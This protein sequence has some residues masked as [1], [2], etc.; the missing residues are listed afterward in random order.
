M[1][2]SRPSLLAHITANQDP[3]VLRMVLVAGGILCL[4]IGPLLSYFFS[5][6]RFPLWV[7][8]ATGLA[9]LSVGILAGFNK[10]IRKNLP[11]I[12]FLVFIL[13]Y[14]ALIFLAYLNRL[15]FGFAGVLLVVQVLFALSFRRLG[16]FA[17]FGM[18]SILLFTLCSL[19][20]SQLVVPA[21]LFVLL[22]SSATIASGLYLWLRE[23][24]Q[25]RIQ[26]AGLLLD[27]MLDHAS[28]AT[29][30]LDTHGRQVLYANRAGEQFFQAQ[31]D[32]S[33]LTAENLL[34]LFDL[35]ASFLIV[36]LKTPGN[37]EE[38]SHALND[39]SEVD[40]Q[41]RKLDLG[42]H[43]AYLIRATLRVTPVLNHTANTYLPDSFLQAI[44]DVFISLDYNGNILSLR[45]PHHFKELQPVGQFL[46]QHFSVLSLMVMSKTKQKEAEQLLESATSSGLVQQ[47]EFMTV[48]AEQ[49]L[50]YDLRIVPVPE[51][52]KILAII[53]DITNNIEVEQALSQSEQNYREIF[54]SV[55][56]GLLILDPH[57]FNAYASNQVASQILGYS[58]EDLSERSFLSLNA[59]PQSAE[60]E[61]LLQQENKSAAQSLECTL[62][63]KG[64]EWIEVELTAKQV[65]LGGN[66]RIML[67]MR[68]ISE[69]LEY[70]Q[71]IGRYTDMFEAADMGMMLLHMEDIENDASLRFITCNPHAEQLIGKTASR[72]AGKSIDEVM[73]HW[74]MLRVPE[75]MAQ[76][77]QSGEP[78]L[79]ED[80][81]YHDR[82]LQPQ[83]WRTKYIPLPGHYLGMLFE[84]VTQQQEREQRLIHSEQRF[85][86]LFNG[87][88]EGIFVTDLKGHILDANPAVC[89]LYQNT[90]EQMRQHTFVALVPE[91]HQ[92]EA[93]IQFEAIVK[94][95]IQ[96]METFALSKNG[97]S[98]P[99]EVRG[100][101]FDFDGQTA[102]ILHLSDISERRAAEDRLRLFRSLINQS[103]DAIFVLDA[104][105]G[106]MLDFNDIMPAS[107]GYTSQEM[108][109]LQLYDFS[110]TLEQHNPLRTE[111][112]M[113]LTATGSS[114]YIGRHRRKDGSSFPVEVNIGSVSL[115]DRDYLV[116]VARDITERLH[117]EAA[118]RQSEQKYRT[119][120]ERMNEGLILT[121]N[122]ETILFVNERMADILGVKSSDLLGHRS[123]QVLNGLD[124]Q[125]AA[126]IR[127]KSALR[128]K[129]ISDQ[130][131]LRLRKT[132]GDVLWVL[133]AGAPYVDSNGDSIGTIA[134][135]TDITNRKQT[136]LKLKEKNNEL[137]A[138]VYKASHDL[139]GPLASIIGLTN[140]ARDEVSSDAAIRYF[141]LIAK[142]TKRLDDI[143]L[144]LIDVTR[145]NKAK[146][147][148]ESINLDETVHD[149]INSL[150]H[151]P[152]SQKVLFETDIQ[153]SNGF[154]TDKK[155]LISVIQNLLVN[156]IN[157]QNPQASPPFVKVRAH[158]NLDRVHFE[159]TDN[160]LG[161]PERLQHRV[162]EMFYRG[163]T[164]SKGSGLGLY[165]VKS[166]IEK[167]QG[168]CELH[169][170]EGIGT[171]INFTLPKDIPISPN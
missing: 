117:N 102:T 163:T 119:L 67:T 52:E 38:R 120:V 59:F 22:I 19:A 42:S 151:Q 70:S 143:L 157:Y 49:N 79:I 133:V 47:M 35:T 71:R 107:L 122:D 66:Y 137:D 147:N 44:P 90:V 2:R 78:M 129:G 138:F 39:G 25:K 14:L 5:G 128:S 4:V 53:R 155:V 162:F 92:M 84:K 121:D 167:L 60:L 68:D 16:D 116:G 76:V 130:Y 123:Y 139:K 165:I 1:A 41:L 105:S 104:T 127:A 113:R 164:K 153:L 98:I 12:A 131:E 34:G 82:N 31:T 3:Y 96:Y 108:R 169:S 124:D 30:L 140:I 63:R 40:L 95:D 126:L 27:E 100:R 125:T 58:D 75:N 62:V 91:E 103:S 110:T 159:V 32:N 166:A 149:I 158:E 24:G 115:F 74:R 171:T 46:D 7:S 148:L 61:Q 150:K 160:G 144:D 26:D 45:S 15:N 18:A 168:T 36:H 152:K 69:K 97:K 17:I 94:G 112:I 51:Q 101:K 86:D 136:E 89:R 33:P 88:P 11:E 134:I 48:V 57:R 64:G 132:N 29:F 109:K 37:V 20:F 135:I 55:T 87:S 6:L 8:L 23:S 54:N 72:I 65:V 21:N 170:E 118:I 10:W 77:V 114:I 83:Y 154:K 80:M 111:D 73:P 56:D 106:K 142:S 99:V 161:I 28:T 146:L 145:I 156:S 43:Y 93:R 13:V 9:G 141:D 81:R 50:Y 85:R